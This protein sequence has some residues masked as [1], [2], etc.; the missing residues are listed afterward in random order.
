MGTKPLFG[1]GLIVYEFPPILIR[2]IPLRKFFIGSGLFPPI[3]FKLAP[4]LQLK[5]L[6]FCKKYYIRK[7]ST[8]QS[9][10][11]VNKLTKIEKNF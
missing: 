6:S 2:H 5:W 1:L 7:P 8:A 4:K 9:S 3:L 11:Y 10:I